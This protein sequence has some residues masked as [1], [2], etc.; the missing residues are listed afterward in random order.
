MNVK[1]ASSAAALAL[2][3][4]GGCRR[5]EVTH[6]RVPKEK[7][8]A[9][10]GLTSAAV[11]SAPPGMAGD[12]PPPPPPSGAARLTWTLP[13]GWT[14]SLTGG[15]RY[16]TLKTPVTGKLDVSVV[17]LPGPAGGELANVNRWRNQIGLPPLDEAAMAKARRT[18]STKAGPLAVYDFTSDGQQKSRVVAGL[19]EAGGSTW[20]LKMTGDEQPVS[21]ARAQ[22]LRLLESLRLD[23]AS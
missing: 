20:F 17:V 2:L 16:A 21:A 23:D 18:V 15:M 6:Y 7:E 22:F 19:A 3:L 4:A 12:V 9:P 14:Q 11:T 13:S 1:A 8:E 5:D 10:A